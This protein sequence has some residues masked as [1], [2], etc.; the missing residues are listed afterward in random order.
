MVSRAPVVE[1][2]VAASVAGVVKWASV[3]SSV[4]SWLQETLPY[5]LK[6]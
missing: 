5:A 6:M 3:L 1:M 4:S 2:L